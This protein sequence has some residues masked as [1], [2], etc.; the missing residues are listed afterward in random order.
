MNSRFAIP[1]SGWEYAVI[2][3]VE[4]PFA[5]LDSLRK[6]HARSRNRSSVAQW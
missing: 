5:L 6:V 2:I 3:V 1:S 4:T